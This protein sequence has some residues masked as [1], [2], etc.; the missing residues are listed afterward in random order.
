MDVFDT[1][2]D[3]PNPKKAFIRPVFSDGR[4]LVSLALARTNGC[5]LVDED[6]LCHF[7]ADESGKVIK[8][9]AMETWGA[10]A[11]WGK[12]INVGGVKCK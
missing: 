5:I 12:P 11:E 6:I 4:R 9:E 2:M 8:A 10:V 3:L 7:P 1:G